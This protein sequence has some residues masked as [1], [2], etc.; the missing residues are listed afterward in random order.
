MSKRPRYRKVSPAMWNTRE[1]R[2]LSA[3][4]LFVKIFIWTHPAMRGCGAMRHTQAGLGAECVWLSQERFA[5]GFTKGLSRGLFE[6]DSDCS[7]VVCRTVVEH[8]PPANP[9]VVKGFL[10]TLGEMPECELLT[11]HLQWLKQFCEPLGKRFAE[12]FPNPLV[13]PSSVL[14]PPSSLLRARQ[15]GG[16]TEASEVLKPIAADRVSKAEEDLVFEAYEMGRR[17]LILV[18]RHD[19][20]G[21]RWR[22]PTRTETRR[23]AIR[24]AILKHGLD[25]CIRAARNINADLYWLGL[26]GGPNDPTTD[27]ALVEVAMR[28]QHID[29]LASMATEETFA[30]V[31][32]RNLARVG[33]QQARNNSWSNPPER[34][35]RGRAVVMDIPG[36]LSGLLA[37]PEAQFREQ[38][39]AAPRWTCESCG[40]TFVGRGPEPPICSAKCKAKADAKRLRSAPKAEGL[41]GSG[42]PDRYQAPFLESRLQAGDLDRKGTWPVSEEGQPVSTQDWQGSPA[43]LTLLGPNGAGKTML[44]VHLLD[45]LRRT[46]KAASL[47]FL[48]PS[49]LLSEERETRLGSLRQL[50]HRAFRCD[51]LV[52]DELGNVGSY[53]EARLWE[54]LAELIEHRYSHHRP[55]IFTSH[56]S[57]GGAPES[58]SGDL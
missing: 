12:V 35:R 11:Q 26:K 6:V 24:A 54:L 56:R 51:A 37:L 15:T 39:Q 1:F 47:L 9:N 21:N 5:K 25:A 49:Q 31:Q 53:N 10:S 36:P 13:T 23:K 29:P 19:S 41:R 43:F 50:Q 8:D 46:G 44:A 32:A 20:S 16:E 17:G 14:R 58:C 57:R 48:R 30:D 55:T 33:A 2:E 18:R 52:V 28:D 22:I 34:C 7:L 4:D 45:R 40:V 38:L 42:V 27:R 3:D